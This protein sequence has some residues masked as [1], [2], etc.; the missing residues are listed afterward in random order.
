MNAIK[1]FIRGFK[2]PIE[3]IIFIF[4]ADISKIIMIQFLLNTIT[5]II[6]LSSTFYIL[7]RWLNSVISYN[8]LWYNHVFYYFALT[9]GIGSAVLLS[10][11]LSGVISGLVGG[12]LNSKLSEKTAE[13][14]KKQTAVQMTGFVEGISR[15]IRFE[16]KNILFI[17]TAFLLLTLLNLI[18]IAGFL[19]F[20]VLTFFYSLFAISFKYWEY[21]MESRKFSFR[22]KLSV[23]WSSGPLFA[24][25]GL[26]SLILF[27]I[28]IVN[29]LAPAVC[30]IAGTLLF[31]N[32][33]ENKGN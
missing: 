16:L 14:Y 13:I 5:F 6:V 18:P 28:P 9:L 27:M 29:F 24:G 20:S 33:F 17:I 31:I 32:E 10:A 7:L 1:K 26:S 23:V 15:D 3:G 30:I 11:V 19:I 22:K 8:S 2:Y 12:G 25:F 21:P 4:S